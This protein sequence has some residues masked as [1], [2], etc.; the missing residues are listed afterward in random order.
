LQRKRKRLGELWDLVHTTAREVFIAQESQAL[1]D[2]EAKV[3]AERQQTL[4]SYQ[5]HVA[6]ILREEAY[7]SGK[8][9][10]LRGLFSKADFQLLLDNNPGISFGEIDGKHSDV[11][12][13]FRDLIYQQGDTPEEILDIMEQ[14]DDKFDDFFAYSA[15]TEAGAFDNLYDALESFKKSATA[16][17]ESDEEDQVQS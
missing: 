9:V 5:G 8:T 11:N 10:W 12:S 2:Q 15:F 16:D 7:Y 17:S 6:V 14:D 4:A 3:E 1:A 13:K